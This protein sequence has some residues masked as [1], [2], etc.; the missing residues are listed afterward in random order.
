MDCVLCNAPADDPH[1][2]RSQRFGS[3]VGIKPDDIYVVPVCR[4]CHGII[5]ANP[6]SYKEDQILWLAETLVFAV[7]DGY[8]FNT[9]Q[10]DYP[11]YE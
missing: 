3:G 8:V 2:I 5:E 7:K 4:G 10:S 9:D 6:E 1:H 11:R